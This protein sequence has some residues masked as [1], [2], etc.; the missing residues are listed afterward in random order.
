MRQRFIAASV[1]AQ[2]VAG[3][4]IEEVGHFAQRFVGVPRGA[5]RCRGR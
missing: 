5:L 2:R 3:T 4:P 1:I